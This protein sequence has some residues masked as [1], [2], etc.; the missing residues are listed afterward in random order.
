VVVVVVV[1]VQQ[2]LIVRVVVWY[3]TWKN[4]VVL[5][6]Y[7]LQTSSIALV[8]CTAAATRDAVA[9]T[10]AEAI[11]YCNTERMRE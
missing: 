7:Q 8:G 1:S 3:R 4:G 2:L 6:K 5:S 10:D 9:L 11:G